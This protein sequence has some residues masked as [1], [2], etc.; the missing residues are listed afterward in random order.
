M[1]AEPGKARSVTGS[2]HKVGLHDVAA[3]AGVGIATVGRVL[4]ERGNVSPDTA[5][6]VIEAARELGLRRILPLPYRRM[7]RLEALIAYPHPSLVTRLNQGF[8][9]LAAMLDRSVIV[10]RTTLR[11]AEPARIAAHIRAART[12]GLMLYAEEHPDVRDAIVAATAAGLPVVCMVTDIPDSG[13]L[14]YVGID[15]ERAGRTA[16]FFAARMMRRPGPVLVVTGNLALRAHAERLAG[17]RA[18]LLAEAPETMIAAVLDGH[19]EDDRVARLLGGALRERPDAA[20]IYNSGGCLSVVAKA[21]GRL[22]RPAGTIFIGHELTD[23][24]RSLMG[25]GIMTLTI[26]QAFE[27]QARRAVE[28][29]LH[30]LGHAVMLPASAG[31][32]FT[33]HTRAN[34]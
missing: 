25:E 28:V 33:L 30:R 11:N 2:G 9:S 32:P 3:L 14:A 8:T 26:D 23:E 18:G 10:E 1:R 31:I 16:G 19:D 20:A 4:N 22:A 29:L 7:L 34:P 24:S 17:F 13:R 6:K 5:R 21:I 12:D 15:N 27:L